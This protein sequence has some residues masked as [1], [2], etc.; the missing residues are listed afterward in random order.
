MFTQCLVF[1]KKNIYTAFWKL[2]WLLYALYL[3]MISILR[4]YKIIRSICPVI[5]RY[6]L[7]L[8]LFHSVCFECKANTGKIIRWNKRS[9]HFQPAGYLSCHSLLEQQFL[10]QGVLSFY[11]L[12]QVMDSLPCAYQCQMAL[13]NTQKEVMSNK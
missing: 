4:N 8:L 10:Y 6:L 3:Q 2:C 12:M 13:L 1:F 9:H 5:L 11:L 7:M